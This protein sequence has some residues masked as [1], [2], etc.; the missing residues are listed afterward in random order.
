MINNLFRELVWNAISKKTEASATAV[1]NLV[2][3]RELAV[4]VSGII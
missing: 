4:N 1:T 3:G 2:P